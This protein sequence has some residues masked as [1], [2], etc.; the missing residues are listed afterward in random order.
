MQP[1]WK[2]IIYKIYKVLNDCI[3]AS[4]GNTALVGMRDFM[5]LLLSIKAALKC[6]RLVTRLAEMI[7]MM[8]YE[9]EAQGLDGPEKIST[10]W[11]ARCHVTSPS[12]K[13]LPNTAQMAPPYQHP[14]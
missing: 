12:S 5:G 6:V 10:R 4:N 11:P 7:Y 14:V 9:E 1:T 8:L 2:S 3:F 13:R